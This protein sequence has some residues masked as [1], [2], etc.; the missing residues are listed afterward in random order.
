MLYFGRLQSL[1]APSRPSQASGSFTCATSFTGAVDTRTLL[2]SSGVIAMVTGTRAGANVGSEAD[3]TR[4]EG[5]VTVRGTAAG[6]DAPR[7]GDRSS[8]LAGVTLDS[9]SSLHW[10]TVI[11]GPSERE[12][13]LLSNQSGCH[14]LRSPEIVPTAC[15]GRLLSRPTRHFRRFQRGA[16]LPLSPKCPQRLK[17]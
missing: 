5:S 17:T 14:S 1:S 8:R 10:I 13:T 12:A 7:H 16:K 15:R 2:G 3:C 4:V 9:S 11:R 6:C